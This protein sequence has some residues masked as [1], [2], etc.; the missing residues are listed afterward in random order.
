LEASLSL[1]DQPARVPFAADESE[2]E[3]ASK[4]TEPSDPTFT[5][6]VACTGVAAVERAKAVKT[7][8][9]NERDLPVN[10]IAPCPFGR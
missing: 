10:F 2:E 3:P 1:G 4:Y 6:G 5:V 8:K 9:T 7:A